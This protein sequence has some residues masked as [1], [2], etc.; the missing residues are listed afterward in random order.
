MRGCV[1]GVCKLVAVFVVAAL[2]TAAPTYAAKAITSSGGGEHSR[3]LVIAHRGA[4][5]V[6]R[7]TPWPLLSRLS[8][9]APT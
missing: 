6:A 4:S 2:C 8:S 3:S 5:G 1:F 7:R 9:L